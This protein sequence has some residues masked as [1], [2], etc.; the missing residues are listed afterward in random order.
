LAGGFS[1]DD[2]FAARMLVSGSPDEPTLH[3]RVGGR[4]QGVG[5]R[6]FVTRAARR[7]GV[8]GWVRNLPDGDVEVL[9]QGPQDALDAL[10]AEV[11][12][13]PRYSRVVRCAVEREASEERFDSFEVRY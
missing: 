9:A 2:A 8:T 7:A 4:V 3:L 13:G 6:Y 11:R 10:V 1:Y 12:Q 5:F